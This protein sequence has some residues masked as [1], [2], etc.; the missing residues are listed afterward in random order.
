MQAKEMHEENLLNSTTSISAAAQLIPTHENDQDARKFLGQ[1]Y[2]SVP[3]F[4]KANQEGLIK[5]KNYN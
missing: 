5:N 3:E 2:L 4:G 1:D